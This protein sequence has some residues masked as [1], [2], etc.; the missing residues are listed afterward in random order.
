M[1]VILLS[2]SLCQSKESCLALCGEVCGHLPKRIVLRLLRAQVPDEASSVLN[3]TT[4]FEAVFQEELKADTGTLTRSIRPR[5]ESTIE[6]ISVEQVE[7]GGDAQRGLRRVCL[8]V[9]VIQSKGIVVLCRLSL[10][11]MCDDVKCRR[12]G[13]SSCTRCFADT[14]YEAHVYLTIGL[15]PVLPASVAGSPT[16]SRQQMDLLLGSITSYSF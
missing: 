8:S 16:L 5:L 11:N 6:T 1:S 13:I 4:A 12:T 3:D 2:G 15:S 14:S 10:S 9:S 7:G